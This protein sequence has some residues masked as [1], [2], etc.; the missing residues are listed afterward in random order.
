MKWIVILCEK[1]RS[2]ALLITSVSIG[3]VV[4]GT[5][6]PVRAVGHDRVP[7]S[8]FAGQAR[9]EAAL[10]T[11]TGI[12][13]GSLRWSKTVGLRCYTGVRGTPTGRYFVGCR[14]N[15]IYAFDINGKIS[16]RMTTTRD[17]DST[18]AVGPRGGVYFGSDEGILYA[19]DRNGKRLWKK[20]LGSRIVS[21]PIVA[22]DGRVYVG[23]R[24]NCLFAFNADGTKA[25]Q[26][27][28]RSDVN[29]S[30]QVA[31]D[32]TVYC[33][34]SRGVVFAV[35][36]DGTLRWKTDLKGSIWGRP[37]IAADGAVFVSTG[38]G[39]LYRL[40]QKGKIIWRARFKSGSKQGPVMDTYGNL[41]VWSRNVGIYGFG[42]DGKRRWIGHIAG[43]GRGYVANGKAGTLLAATRKGLL[44]VLDSNRKPAWKIKLDKK[45][46]RGPPTMHGDG[47]VLVPTDDGVVRVVPPL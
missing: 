13:I 17:V 5:G 7:V 41:Y 42:L 39:W 24:N 6:G 30:P 45:Y 8:A 26:Q 37:Q 2:F 31:P 34:T 12:G 47:S 23:S 32:G 9:K 43:C 35:R 40:D 10:L 14:D 21:S 11:L 33:G 36:H 44:L 19:L 4:C 1:H 3:M 29:A 38:A 18:P 22:L 46:I 16:W 28:M 25:W 20:N 15:R 27:C